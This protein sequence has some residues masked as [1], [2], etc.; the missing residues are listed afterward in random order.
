MASS[1]QS[2]GRDVVLTTLNIFIQT[3]SIA[4][5]ACGVPPAQVA[6]SS[7]CVLLTMIQVSFPYYARPM[8]RL[9][10]IQDTMANDQDYVEIGQVCGE[11]CEALYQRLKG[12]RSD[13]LNKPVLGAIGT[14]TS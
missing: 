4:K 5:D 14:L 8:L 13:E 1:Q 11:V 12:R 6:L 7:A 2:K 9:T 3:L 10:L